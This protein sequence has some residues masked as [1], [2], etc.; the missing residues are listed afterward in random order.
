MRVCYHPDYFVELPAGHPFPMRKFPEL[1]RILLAD[2]TLR[3]GDVVEP[4][5]AELDLL[6]LVHTDDYL[7]KL[8][9]GNL[10]AADERRIGI[11]WSEGL[12]RRSRLAV[13]GTLEAARMALEDGYAG[14][15]AGG[16][17][18]AFP[19]HGQGYCV[20]NDVAVAIRRLLAE[21]RVA[22]P[23]VVDL[24]VHQGNGT[25]AIFAEDPR[26]FTFS[27]H[28]EKN[29]P[30]RKTVSDRDVAL[31]C[32]IGDDEYLV[33]LAAELG[34]LMGRFGPD[35]LFYLAGVDPAAGDRYGRMALT[36]EGLAARDRHVLDAARGLGIPLVLLLAGGYA[37]T[38]TRTAELHAIAFRMAVEVFEGRA[39]LAASA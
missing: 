19:D 2:G 12:W 38:P 22:R 29:F 7:W 21:G 8:A 4:E 33:R 32:G 39:A 20:L 35:C 10:E 17:H 25:A 23:M 16:T 24:D 27:M 11:P 13:G 5:E 14:N 28:G 1:H 9:T 15:L 31:P 18:H 6:G 30:A 26:V 3:P 36:E 37:T 34:P